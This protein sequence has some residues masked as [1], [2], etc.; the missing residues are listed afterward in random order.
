M[1]KYK[2]K[3]GGFIALTLTLSVAGILLALVAASSIDSALF[4]DQALRKEYRALNYYYAGDC[5]DQAILALAHDYFFN[6]ASPVEIQEYHCV[7]LS[8]ENQGDIR[9]ISAKGNL[10]NADVYRSA[11][12]Q[13]H[14]HSLTL[15]PSPYL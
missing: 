2:I 4:F 1:N 13:L 6:P 3:K 10:Q 9:I 5:L 11:T 8:V 12:V 7:I 15:L 14:D